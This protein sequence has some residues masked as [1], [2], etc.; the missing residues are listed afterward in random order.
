MKTKI[1]AFFASLVMVFMLFGVTP[2]AAF[3]TGN[4]TIGGFQTASDIDFNRNNG[5]V[6][7]S[8]WAVGGQSYPIEYRVR[9]FNNAQT[10]TY[11]DTGYVPWAPSSPSAY[12]SAQ[13]YLPNTWTK[14]LIN[15]GKYGDNYPTCEM[16][17]NIPPGN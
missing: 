16:W 6:Y 7:F 12:T 2:A 17:Y 8:H 10:G 1:I 11:Y 13:V 5:T 3:Q 15:A 4:C 14:V 9:W